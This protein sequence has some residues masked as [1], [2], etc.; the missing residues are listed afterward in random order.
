MKT[1]LWKTMQFKTS[2]LHQIILLILMSKEYF[3]I[4]LQE[5]L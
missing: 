2:Y 4:V 5:L 3:R 1:D